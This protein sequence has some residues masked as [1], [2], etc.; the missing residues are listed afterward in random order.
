MIKNDK[1]IHSPWSA[2]AKEALSARIT[3][4][5]SKVVNVLDDLPTPVGWIRAT[6]INTQEELVKSLDNEI[7]VEIVRKF[8]LLQR[9]QTR[10][11]IKQKIKYQKRLKFLPRIG[12]RQDCHC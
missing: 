6:D 12:H 5:V 8:N 9:I 10:G 11:C 3:A 7:R 4:T 1:Y 2:E